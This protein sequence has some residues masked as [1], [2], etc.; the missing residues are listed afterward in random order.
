[1]LETLGAIFSVSASVTYLVAGL[2]MACALLFFQMTQ[3]RTLTLFFVPVAAVGALVGI[4]VSRELGFYYS[5]E[6]NSNILLSSLLGLMV[7]LVIVIVIARIAYAISNA[8][9]R[10][11]RNKL[12]QN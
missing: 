3:S 9:R 1:M 7:S 5:T 6:E 2:T 4:Y 12:Q 11:Q 10:N 8:F